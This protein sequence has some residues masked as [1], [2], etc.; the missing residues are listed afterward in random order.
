MATRR[1][2]DMA[3]R[4]MFSRT[5]TESDAF[6][7]LPL[8]AQALWFHMGMSADD[9][10]IVN[11]PKRVQRCIGATDDDARLL[12][13]KGFIVAFDSGVIAIRDWRVNNYIRPDRYTPT[14]YQAELAS[15]NN[16]SCLPG[17]IPNVIP[18]D[19]PA[20]DPGKDRLGKDRLGKSESSVTQVQRPTLEEVTAYCNQRGNGIDPERF[21][22]YY[23][24]NGWRVGKQP[25]RDWKAAVRSWEKRERQQ[26]GIEH[27]FSAYNV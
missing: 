19:I 21:I 6:T 27:D 13:A 16:G 12:L 24:A 8:S 22:D 17:D 23:T 10:G 4:R 15:L 26:G 25:M 11:N 20:V 18:N 1:A 5:I 14:V 2:V 9:D 3:N 7:D